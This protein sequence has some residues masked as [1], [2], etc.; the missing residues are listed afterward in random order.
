MK[1]CPIALCCAGLVFT[2]H[3]YRDR[4]DDSINRMFSRMEQ[5]LEDMSK[6]TT[7]AHTVLVT[8]DGGAVR[9]SFTV[10]KSV[11]AKD[12]L[13][14]VEDGVLHLVIERPERIELL[15]EERWLTLTAERRDSRDANSSFACASQQLTLPAV[16]DISTV[17]VDL[18][19][20]ELTL[21][22]DKNSGKNRQ[23]VAVTQGGTKKAVPA[24]AVPAGAVPAKKTVE[25]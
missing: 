18:T 3:A 13:V 6:V 22:F 2:A 8:E 16:V 5:Q 21:S 10:D 12:V 19:D 15:V 17:K 20:G 14:E 23:L 4:F 25:K 24:A 7:Y 9:V 11:A 1:Y